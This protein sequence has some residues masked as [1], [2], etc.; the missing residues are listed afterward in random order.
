[1]RMKIACAGMNSS[2]AQDPRTEKAVK[3][4]EVA[5]VEPACP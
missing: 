5:G 4:V 3:M 2:A 1:M